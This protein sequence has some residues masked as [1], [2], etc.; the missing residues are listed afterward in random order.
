MEPPN[1]N[2]D[3]T[4]ISLKVL[5]E[6]WIDDDL[7]YLIS[8]KRTNKIFQEIREKYPN[9]WELVEMCREAI[10]ENNKLSSA[11]VERIQKIE[12]DSKRFI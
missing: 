6:E 7:R 12:T 11:I 9:N 8:L 10:F 4:E 5:Y 2:Q 3:G 1:Q